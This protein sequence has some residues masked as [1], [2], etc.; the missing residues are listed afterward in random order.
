MP[1]TDARPRFPRSL[2]KYSGGF[3]LRPCCRPAA[4]TDRPGTT[5]PQGGQCRAS[6]FTCATM[7][8]THGGSSGPMVSRY[9]RR[10]PKAV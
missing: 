2:K 5:F 1:I 7:A 4:S 8:Q 6:S 10:Y 9:S 3:E